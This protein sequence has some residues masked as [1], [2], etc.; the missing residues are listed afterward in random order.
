ME[1]VATPDLRISTDG[2]AAFAR[3]GG[4]KDKEL[5]SLLQ[6]RPESLRGLFH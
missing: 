1:D 6:E 3:D 2:G 5:I 4:F